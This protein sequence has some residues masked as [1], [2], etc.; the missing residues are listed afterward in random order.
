VILE[1]LDIARVGE[2]GNALYRSGKG[3]GVGTLDDR[4]N[5]GSGPKY[6]DPISVNR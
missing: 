4:A 2:N 3:F 6:N 1:A 5:R